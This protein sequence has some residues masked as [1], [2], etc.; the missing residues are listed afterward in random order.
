MPSFTIHGNNYII[1]GTTLGENPSRENSD[2]K[3]HFGFKQ[4]LTNAILPWDTYLF[5]TEVI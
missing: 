4:R 2:T 3:L 1:T 5:F